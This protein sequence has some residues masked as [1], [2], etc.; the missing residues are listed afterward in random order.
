MLKKKFT[1]KGFTLTEL[2]VVVI[3]VGILASLAIPRFGKSTDRAME[4][5]AKIALRQIQELEKVYYLENKTFSKNLEKLGFEQEL[6]VEQ[7]PEQG[8]AR[9]RIEIVSAGPDDFLA[10]A[11]P[12]VRDLRAYTVGKQGKPVVE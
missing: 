11:V 12:V 7:D 5:E 6:T 2:L 1:R 10:R 3:L 9:Y 8:T 4:A